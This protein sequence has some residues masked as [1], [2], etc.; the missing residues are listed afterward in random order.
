MRVGTEQEVLDE[1]EER[2]VQR[3]FLYDNPTEY[4][5]GVEATIA[6]LREEWQ[7]LARQSRA[8]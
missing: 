6:V 7:R 1:I 4:S 3:R 8:G 2:L 5:N